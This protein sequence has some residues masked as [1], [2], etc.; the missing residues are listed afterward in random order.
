MSETFTWNPRYN[1]AVAR[2]PRIYMAQ[3]GD[4]YCQRVAHGINT[5]P[6]IYNLSFQLIASEI[7]AI[8]AFLIARNGVE[9]FIWVPPTGGTGLWL[10]PTWTRASEAGFDTIT[11]TF[12]EVFGD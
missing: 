6:R 5:Q 8:D 12:N 3:F 2:T 7:D 1:A 9:S 4:G 11:A 10:C